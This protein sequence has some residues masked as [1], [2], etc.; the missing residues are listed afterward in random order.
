M[1]E[2]ELKLAEWYKREDI[3]LQPDDY[4]LTNEM[5]QE[6]KEGRDH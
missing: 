3:I 2:N 1:D 6:F 4:S 5:M